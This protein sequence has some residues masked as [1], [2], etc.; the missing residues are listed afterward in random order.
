[1]SFI[2]IRPALNTCLFTVRSLCGHCAVTVRSLCGHRAVTVRSPGKLLPE[3]LAA[4]P[5]QEGGKVAVLAELGAGERSG[6]GGRPV[7]LREQLQPLEQRV[8]APC[9]LRA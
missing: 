3:L 2:Y 1:M 9:I 4:G 8:Q 6:L 5:L 7:A